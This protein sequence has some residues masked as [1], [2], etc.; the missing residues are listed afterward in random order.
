MTS[1]QLVAVFEGLGCADVATFLASGNVLFDG[2]L[3]PDA[4]A[5]ALQSALGYAVPTTIRSGQELVAIAELEPFTAADVE[6]STGKP[7]VM[8]LFN[9]PSPKGR[10]EA[11]AMAEPENLLVFGNRELHWLPST[12]MSESTLDLKRIADLVGTNTV[13]TA[14][15]IARLVGKL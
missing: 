5:G 12:G 14:N 3:D 8:L 10:K 1:D 15:T 6:A 2:D 4:A 9:E 7:Q 13:R 11:L